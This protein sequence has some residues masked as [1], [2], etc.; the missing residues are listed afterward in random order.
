MHDEV[1]HHQ[2]RHVGCLCGEV[3]QGDVFFPLTG[4]GYD[5]HLA[6]CAV[7]SPFADQGT[8]LDHSRIQRIEASEWM[9]LYLGMQPKVAD[10]DC[11]T[12][13]GPHIRFTTLKA[14]F[15]HHLVA[16]AEFE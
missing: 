8:L 10:F 4:W 16:E 12:T 7:S 6:R 14:Y 15:E 3:A 1:Y 11:Q 2:P 5:D 9:T 13:N